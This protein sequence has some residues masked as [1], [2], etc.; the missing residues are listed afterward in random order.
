MF[1]YSEFNAFAISVTVVGHSLGAEHLPFTMA[2]TSACIFA[3]VLSTMTCP[4]LESLAPGQAFADFVDS[5]LSGFVTHVNNQEDDPERAWHSVLLIPSPV[6]RD[7]LHIFGA[8]DTCPGTF[9]FFLHLRVARSI[10]LCLRNLFQVRIILS[11][12]ASA[13]SV[14]WRMSSLT[15]SRDT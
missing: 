2:S 5:Q 7:N 8:W 4:V 6:W 1:F 13:L 10:G 3:G 12:Y 9:S 15:S 11:T 14:M